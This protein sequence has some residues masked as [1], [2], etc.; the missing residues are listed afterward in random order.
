MLTGIFAVFL[1]PYTQTNAAIITP[2][3]RE[4]F[5]QNSFQFIFI[6]LSSDAIQSVPE[7]KVN[8]LGC[9]SIGH[10]KQNKYI[11]T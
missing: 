7:E 6:H 10:Y 1:N 11:R 5:L 2:L 4:R 3:H 8:I 9:H